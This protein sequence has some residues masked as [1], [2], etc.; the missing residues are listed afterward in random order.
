MSLNKEMIFGLLS[1]GGDDMKWPIVYNSINELSLSKNSTYTLDKD[2]LL[3]NFGNGQGL[4]KAN[5]KIEFPDGQ[6]IEKEAVLEI[7]FGVLQLLCPAGTKF[8]NT[9]ASSN[10]TPILRY[11]DIMGYVDYSP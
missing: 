6:F 4:G 8:T 9:D 1:F 10:Y 11:Y 2:V 5:L 7:P 3:R